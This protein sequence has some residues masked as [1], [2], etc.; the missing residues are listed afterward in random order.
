MMF[1][2]CGYSA[3]IICS[4]FFVTDFLIFLVRK[5]LGNIE[6]KILYSGLKISNLIRLY[7]I[8]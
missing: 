2:L 6:I 4:S 5:N 7:K 8:I 3:I 1:F